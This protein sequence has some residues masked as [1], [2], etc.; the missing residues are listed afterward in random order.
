MTRLISHI[1][2]FIVIAFAYML[3]V[4][5]ACAFALFLIW[6]WITQGQP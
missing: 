2:R 6:G 3:A 1:F 5:A 4:T